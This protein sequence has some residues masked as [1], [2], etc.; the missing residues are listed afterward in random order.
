MKS[1]LK[2]IS[3][4]PHLHNSRLQ[5]EEGNSLQDDRKHLFV[6]QFG[7]FLWV[8]FGLC[9]SDKCGNSLVL[10]SR[11][12]VSQLLKKVGGFGKKSFHVVA[13]AGTPPT[14]GCG[15]L[16]RSGRTEHYCSCRS[17]NICTNI[18]HATV[19]NTP[20]TLKLPNMVQVSVEH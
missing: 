5:W 1:V 8:D 7:I 14:E 2:C 19:F 13:I 6:N 16:I 11:T 10:V 12:K 4:F 15:C 20:I 18:T 9:K 17:T 3:D